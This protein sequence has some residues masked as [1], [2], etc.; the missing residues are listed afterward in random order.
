M[1][2]TG[3]NLSI[4]RLSLRSSSEV[5]DDEDNIL[6]SEQ[7][8][9]WPVSMWWERMLVGEGLTLLL[10]VKVEI[11]IWSKMRVTTGLFYSFET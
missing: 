10:P 5:D 8:M 3:F 2:R 7:E 9:G 6:K 11:P 4:R 1:L